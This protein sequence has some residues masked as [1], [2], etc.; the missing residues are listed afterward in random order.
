VGL[1]NNV[2]ESC[3]FT[4]QFDPTQLP[5]GPYTGMLNVTIGDSTIRVISEAQDVGIVG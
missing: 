1:G 5:S 4:V 2:A 3:T